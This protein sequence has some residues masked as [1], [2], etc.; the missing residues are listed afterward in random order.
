MSKV[1]ISFC[2]EEWDDRPPQIDFALDIELSIYHTRL[3]YPDIFNVFQQFQKN[4]SC[5]GDS[6]VHICAMYLNVNELE[7]LKGNKFFKSSLD[8]SLC[9]KTKF[10]FIDCV[11]CNS[12]ICTN[13]MEQCRGYRDVLPLE[14]ET[15][16][17]DDPDY[18]SVEFDG[19]E[20]G[21]LF[22]CYSEINT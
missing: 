16:L 18:I 11:E 19:P 9:R 6:L 12:R 14:L 15:K 10:Q 3:L 20:N 2:V 5:L 4:F 13:C 8:C 21:C 22:H 7:N 1:L 17:F